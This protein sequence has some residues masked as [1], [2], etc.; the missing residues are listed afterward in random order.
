MVYLHG[1][2]MGPLPLLGAG[3]GVLVGF[4]RSTS[5]SLSGDCWILN[6]WM[7]WTALARVSSIEDSREEV[8]Y[9]CDRGREELKRPKLGDVETGD[10]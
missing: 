10:V 3:M 8:R 9:I 7:R 5:E 1:C 6:G 4:R 2:R